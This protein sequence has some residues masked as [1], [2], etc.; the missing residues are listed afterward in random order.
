VSLAHQ[1]YAKRRDQNEPEIVQC[2]QALGF[3][4]VRLDV[5][6]DLLVTR[7]GL[8]HQVEIKVG[9][10]KLTPDQQEYVRK[11]KAPVHILRDVTGA[12]AWAKTVP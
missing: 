9:K 10:G 5:P 11:T 12:I 3:H 4:V 8:V 1:K 7:R 6:C 2:L